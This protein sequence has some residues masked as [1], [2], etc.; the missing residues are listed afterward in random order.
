[1][2]SVLFSGFAGADIEERGPILRL[3]TCGLLVPQVLTLH[4]HHRHVPDGGHNRFPLGALPPV[5]A[6]HRCCHHGGDAAAQ[7]SDRNTG[8]E[9][10]ISIHPVSLEFNFDTVWQPERCHQPNGLRSLQAEGVRGASWVRYAPCKQ[11]NRLTSGP[12]R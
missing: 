4:L 10:A 8:Y 7:P 2:A 9:A 11:Y 12:R 1:M 5:T 6:G 3:H